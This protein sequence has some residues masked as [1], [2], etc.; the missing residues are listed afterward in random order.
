MSRFNIIISGYYGFN[1]AGDEAMLSAIL[2]ALRAAFSDPQITVISGNPEITAHTFHVHAIS[3][4]GMKDIIRSIIHSDLLIS[5]GGSL[6]QDVT[7][8]KS[9]VYYLSIIIIGV[10]FRKKVFLYS[11]GI[12][13]VRYRVIR[14]LLKHVLNHVTA[15][16]VRD[17]DSKGFLERLGVHSRIYTTADAV[18]SLSAA[19]LDFGQKVLTENHIPSDKKRVGIAIR[20]WG[21]DAD[22]M[23]SLKRYVTKL[24][25]QDEYSIVFIPMQH[26]EDV[27]AA[28]SVGEAGENI[29][30]LRDSYSIEEILSIIG[31]MDIV[32]GMR[33]HAL[34]FA[35][36]M[37]VPFLGISYDPKIDNFLHL[38]HSERV[39]SVGA[40]DEAKL[41]N[42]TVEILTKKKVPDYWADV[43][44]LQNRAC[45]NVRIL[46]ELIKPKG[47]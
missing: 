11:Q 35:S 14:I 37:H 25:E 46:K 10:L 16:T 45:E 24:A 41:Y 42:E 22:W 7:S 47:E 32:V 39:C 27:R 38:I 43:E 15:I 5:G 18:L 36:L 20:N 33:L 9:M 17:E 44:Y 19:P 31:N 29:Y 40:M 34:I 6:L 30:I 1:N 12:G 26:P 23:K 2:N 28:E 8:W 21:Q 3:R 4:F 13:P